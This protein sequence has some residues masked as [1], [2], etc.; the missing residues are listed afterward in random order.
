VKV[1]IYNL[2]WTTFG[3][4][5][6]QAGGIADALSGEHEVELLGPSS[7]DLQLLR[8][9][10]GLR[11]DGVTFRRIPADDLSAT[12]ASA[13]Y[14]VFFNHT[15]RS[16][17]P[18]LARHGVYFV[19]FPHRFRE[20]AVHRGARSIAGAAAAP[21]RVV[22]GVH[23][24]TDSR[25]AVVEGPVLVHVAKDVRSLIVEFDAEVAEEIAVSVVRRGAPVRREKLFGHTTVEVDLSQEPDGV[26]GH[27]VLFG[28]APRKESSLRLTGLALDGRPVDPAPR[29]FRQRLLHMRPEAFLETYDSVVA[30]SDY[31]LGWTRTWWGRGEAVLSP[32]VR[33][34]APGEKE[35]LIVAIGRFFDQ[36]SGHSKQQLE[37][38][39]AFRGLV[40]RGLSG[41]RFVLIGG[42]NGPDREYAMAV[43]R[44][45]RGLPIEVHLNAP[46]SFLDE[47]IGKA[48]FLWHAAGLGADLQA[49]PDRAEHF[50]IAPIEAM[51]AGVV[52]L[53]FA[54]AGPTE[55]VRHGVDGLHFHSAD[56]LVA[57]TLD[58]IADGPRRERLAAAAIQRAHGYDGAH[59]EAHVRDLVAKVVAAAG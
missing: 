34:R 9:R 27:E 14:D 13:D 24:L 20:S 38:V 40:E 33:M 16:T 2:Y 18:N 31:T 43:R 44:E 3:G 5:E 48:T 58:L 10:L 7:V 49:H 17:A 50:G 28:A 25:G 51:S 54:A 23:P 8:D 1:G 22:A 12:L 37:L 15:Y 21:A 59:F 36:K 26:E 32:P 6:Q 55:V 57:Q 4:G 29:S 56:E 47:Q 42:C 19:M 35:Q 11:L 39:R 45:A 41:W 46:G 52:P 53:V 30:L